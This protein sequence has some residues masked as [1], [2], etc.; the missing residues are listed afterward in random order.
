M[1][2]SKY[3]SASGE[4]FGCTISMPINFRPPQ[5]FDT[6]TVSTCRMHCHSKHATIAAVRRRECYCIDSK[7]RLRKL[8]GLIKA[9]A[10]QNE[11]KL[12]AVS[13]SR[14]V[15]H[16]FTLKISVA[17]PDDKLE[18]GE[19][20][21]LDMRTDALEAVKFE[22]DLGDGNKRSVSTT[23]LEYAWKQPGT[24]NVQVQAITRKKTILRTL[25]VPVA[26]AER[27]KPP[28]VVY[29]VASQQPNTFT[30]H[31][32]VTTLGTKP[33]ACSIEF[34]NGQRENFAIPDTDNVFTTAIKH[35]YQT[36]GIYRTAVKCKNQYGIAEQSRT[37]FISDFAT[38]RES[39]VVASDF[40]LSLHGAA[41]TSNNVQAKV[42]GHAVAIVKN[43]N[44]I[45]VPKAA[46]QRPNVY[47]IEVWTGTF[48]LRKVVLIVEQP[49]E[50]GSLDVAP[51]FGN[52]QQVYK[53]SSD[54]RGDPVFCELATRNG[55]AEYFYAHGARHVIQDSHKFRHV[56]PYTMALNCCNRLGCDAKAMDVSVETPL[57][58]VK[59]VP[60]DVY[61]VNDKV[62]MTVSLNLKER[63]VV[64]RVNAQISFG[65]NTA[66]DITLTT[67]YDTYKEFVIEHKYDNYGIYMINT[68][69]SNNISSVEKS[70]MVQVG[71]NLTLVDLS[72][73]TYRLSTA[74][75]EARIGIYC[76]Q[77]SMRQY[78]LDL[79]DGT[80]FVY[81]ESGDLKSTIPHGVKP[82][83]KAWNGGNITVIH[84]YTQPG[85]YTVNVTVSN[86][87]GS[88][89]TTLCP[90]IIVA[91]PPKSC[92]HPTV[93]FDKIDD[94]SKVLA[95]AYSEN[96]TLNL[97]TLS[98]CSDNKTARYTWRIE[99]QAL[100]G[101]IR[102]LPAHCVFRSQKSE[103][104]MAPFVLTYGSYWFT[105]CVGLG[106]SELYYAC[107]TIRVT[108][109][110]SNLRSFI[111]GGA[112]TD[113]SLPEDVVVNYTRSG[114]PDVRAPLVDTSQFDL[115]C[116]RDGN[117][118]RLD[119]LASLPDAIRQSTEILSDG[120]SK[121]YDFED[122]CFMGKSDK[123]TLAAKVLTIPSSY[124]GDTDR[125]L[126]FRLF[127]TK[128]ER[129]SVTDQKVQIWD[130]SATDLDSLLD[131]NMDEMLNKDVDGC[132]FLIT[133]GAE[134]L[135]VL[136]GVST[137][138]FQRIRSD[139]LS[140]NAIYSEFLE[141]IKAK[142]CAKHVKK[143]TVVMIV[144]AIWNSNNDFYGNISVLYLF[145]RRSKIVLYSS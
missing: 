28:Q 5:T 144:K 31:I 87:F 50:L 81:P 93:Y 128:G 115:I 30:A 33:L 64:D 7:E 126:S 23:S 79:G 121:V 8:G 133:A 84:T 48:V 17:T 11:Y 19:T 29:L 4:P 103:L 140:Y 22:V 70:V 25:D 62:V 143:R 142:L 15:N 97:I 56:G 42:N 13:T 18:T 61:D 41:D 102:P 63:T 35:T 141:Q 94:P 91:T 20:V 135:N 43:V 76:P 106:V 136:E 55:G 9:C 68:K 83:M 26:K 40:G 32:S 71:E 39:R 118:Q 24:F 130:P 92:R 96:I 124:I 116:F 109:S 145:R 89:R 107:K 98:D 53:L 75:P 80:I 10:D 114:D 69:F 88:V 86:H 123:V 67:P 134:K 119:Q 14:E 38:K 21:R 27:G 74:S 127:V 46:F 105:G 77:G 34:G 95:K 58:Q 78:V 2:F 44:A 129:Q 52:L 47:D 108:I 111:E 54:L 51:K 99:R 138:H 59:V 139:I 104:Y 131:Q 132:L 3:F 73:D 6:Q 36:A 49:V 45:V 120:N 137:S 57:M 110:T 85:Y 72:T 122:G 1:L 101:R 60:T 100:S 66:Q 12:F 37:L 65:D 90:S 113:I 125:S 112:R 117:K 16:D 82:R